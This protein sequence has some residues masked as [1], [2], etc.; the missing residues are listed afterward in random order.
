RPMRKDPLW[1]GGGI[2]FSHVFASH[3]F[4]GIGSQFDL[5][6]INEAVF[7]NGRFL[8]AESEAF[9]L[10]ALS[11]HTGYRFNEAISLYALLGI[12]RNVKNQGFS[13]EVG[14]SSTL[15]GFAVLNTGVGLEARI[16]PLVANVAAGYPVALEEYIHLGPTVTAQLGFA[17][18]R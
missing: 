11:W 13:Y 4:L 6:L 16:G 9:L 18:G 12:Q 1:G 3:A 2:R 8:R 14:S 10:P 5:A 15:S 17:F 7:V